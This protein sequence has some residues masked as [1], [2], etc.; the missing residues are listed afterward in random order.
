MAHTATRLEAEDNALAERVAQGLTPVA[1]ALERDMRLVSAGRDRESA[2]NDPALRRYRTNR[3]VA[4][5]APALRDALAA[6]ASEGVP[7]L[8]P[9]TVAALTREPPASGIDASLR[10][11]VP[12]HRRTLTPRRTHLGILTGF[13]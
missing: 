4:D 11:L 8:A 13:L 9:E 7:A 10:A 12:R 1:A 2:A 5:I 3:A 6:L